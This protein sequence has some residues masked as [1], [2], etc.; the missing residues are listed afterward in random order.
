M[1]DV[2]DDDDFAAWHAVFDAGY[3]VG[4]VDPPIWTVAELLVSYRD[5]DRSWE[6]ELFAAVEDGV[7]VGAAEVEYPLRDNQNLAEFGIAVPA[8]HR[9]RGIGSA[10]YDAVAARITELG[11]PVIG[12]AVNQ[13]VNAPE[14]PGVAFLTKRGLTRRNTEA[15]RV[16]RLPVEPSLLDR[17]ERRA[18]ERS[19]GYRITTWRDSC[20]DE[21]AE[22]YA[23]LK[24]LLSVQAPLGELDYELEHWDV[25][26]LR[27]EER[28]TAEQR[29]T[30]LTAVAVAPDGTLA[31][32]TQ[33]AIPGLEAHKAYQWDTLVLPDHRGHRLGALLKL[34]NLRRLAEFRDRDRIETWN[35]L[36]N[37]HM[38]AI[39]DELGFETVEH[40]EEWQSGSAD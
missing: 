5:P 29:R 6:H 31:G 39:N 1:V 4:R 2:L 30:I 14:E 40:F 38:N 7:V 13:P 21:Y 34:I 18:L 23:Q 28:V 35:A 9:R 33:I 36:Q 32:H 27:A 16:L 10:L 25:E 15:R 8:E 12:T 22:Q 11:R 26:R 24:A 19:G 17:M 3:R 37:D 20:P